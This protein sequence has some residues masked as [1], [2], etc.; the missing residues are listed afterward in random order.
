[1][2]LEW[3]FPPTAGG[4][5]HGINNTGIEIYKDVIESLVREMGQNSGDASDGEGLPVLLTFKREVVKRS[6]IPGLPELQSRFIMCR[7]TNRDKFRDDEA[8]AFFNKALELIGKQNIECLRVSDCFTTGA[9]GSD[10]DMSSGWFKLVKSN[11][12]T[13]KSYASGDGGSFGIG[14]ASALAASQFR[15]VYYSTLTDEGHNFIGSA[16]LTTHENPSAPYSLGDEISTLYQAKIYFGL[17]GGHSVSD[18]KTIP[19]LFRRKSIGLD[20]FIAAFDFAKEWEEDIAVSVIKNFWPA[21]LWEKFECEVGEGSKKIEINNRTLEGLLDK[22]SQKEGFLS[23]LYYKAYKEGLRNDAVMPNLCACSAHVVAG[24]GY[25]KKVA[26][27]RKNGMIIEERT[28]SSRTPFVGVFE[29]SNED[30]N[31][32]LRSMEPPRHDKWDPNRPSPKANIAAEKEFKRV[33]YDA[34]KEINAVKNAET[35]LVTGLEELLPF[36]ENIKEFNSS[37][38]KTP[39]Y[40][41][42]EKPKQTTVR[43]M[44]PRAGEPRKKKKK[45]KISHIKIMPRAIKTANGYTIKIRHSGDPATNAFVE[46]N[47]AGDGM[48]ETATIKSATDSSG[49]I[50]PILETKNCFGPVTLNKTNS[51]DIKLTTKRRVSLEV[52]AYHEA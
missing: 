29:C 30:G 36:D 7:N 51:F 21:I 5:I 26:M 9:L 38:A 40:N 46:V 12:T 41:H 28:F 50:I 42:A 45:D 4:D 8:V 18:K 10:K 32:I 11:G 52:S 44:M 33:V 37:N 22:Y 48:P 14:K 1:M 39:T 3:H 13:T 43:A 34:I 2:T 16:M 15:T 31:R 49:M 17:P 20:A 6:E 35:G 47:I 24:E 19:E 27:I 23:H 25:P